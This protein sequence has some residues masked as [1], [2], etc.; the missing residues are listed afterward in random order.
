MLFPLVNVG[1]LVISPDVVTIPIPPTSDAIKT[2]NG[3]DI[4]TQDGEPIEIQ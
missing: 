2:Q 4:L 1:T 3:L